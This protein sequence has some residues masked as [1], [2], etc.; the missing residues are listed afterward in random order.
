M[1]LLRT[2]DISQTRFRTQTRDCRRS[3]NEHGRFLPATRTRRLRG[4]G[5]RLVGTRAVRQSRWH[6]GNGG[7]LSRSVEVRANGGVLTRSR[8]SRAKR[9]TRGTRANDAHERPSLMETGGCQSRGN[10]VVRWGCQTKECGWR[11]IRMAVGRLLGCCC[12]CRLDRGFEP[13]VTN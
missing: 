4:L 3:R 10:G 7:R 12:L 11:L 13:E 1:R 5:D 9:T 8:G 6:L 2:A